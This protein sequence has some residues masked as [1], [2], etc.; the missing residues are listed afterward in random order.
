MPLASR[1]SRSALEIGRLR[2]LHFG[3]DQLH[4]LLQLGRLPVPFLQLLQILPG[5]RSTITVSA[6]CFQHCSEHQGAHV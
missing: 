1:R 3:A 4:H 2:L 5:L 6:A